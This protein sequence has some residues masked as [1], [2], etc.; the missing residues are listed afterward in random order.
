MAKL[1]CTIGAG[2]LVAAEAFD[3]P[4]VEFGEVHCFTSTGS[5]VETSM[6]YQFF[7]KFPEVEFS[8]SRLAGFETLNNEA[9][10]AHF[11]EGLWRWYLSHLEDDKPLYVC[12]AGGFKSMSASMQKAAQLFGAA[13]VFHVLCENEPRTLPDLEIARKA[14][15]IRFINLGP[16]TGWEQLRQLKGRYS[17]DVRGGRDGRDLLLE[18]EGDDLSNESEARM[19][20]AARK[21]AGW[22]Q[23]T[24][25]P[26]PSLALLNREKQAW[27]DGPLDPKRDREWVRQLPKIELH[28]HLG[29]FA[30]HPPLLDQVRAAAEIALEKFVE[31]PKVPKG[32]PLPPEPIGLETYCRLGDATGSALLS[33]PG[34]LRKQIELLYAHFQQENI[35]YAEVR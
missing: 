25:V 28:S 13:Q 12:L 18:I 22:Q 1:L 34:S 23:A 30:T 11:Q 14:G 10:H 16:E 6:L 20:L 8:V 9:D 4:G 17:L 27:L 21:A 33:D 3:F 15:R 26:F 24:L 2:V 7:G 19:E 29:G 5:I 32:W 31:I 35:L